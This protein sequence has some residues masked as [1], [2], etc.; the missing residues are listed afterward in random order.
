MKAGTLVKTFRELNNMTQADLAKHLTENVGLNVSET[1]IGRWERDQRH[2]PEPVVAYMQGGAADSPIAPEPGL[3]DGAPPA[4]D[5]APPSVPGGVRRPAPSLQLSSVTYEAACVDLWEM[6][7]FGVK[8]FGQAV[9]NPVL[10]TDGD[11]IDS[12]KQ[13]LGRAYGKLAE[14][15]DTFR[16]LVIGLTQGGIWVEVTSVTVK[17]AVTIAQNHQAYARHVAE[18]RRAAAET[19]HGDGGQQEPTPAADAA[20]HQQAA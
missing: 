14:K 18:Q 9:R 19:P 8:L 1:T 15:N 12:Q 20:P 3:D 5:D 4:A 6:I 7:G 2:T 16:R 13:D 17:M 11:I 10:M